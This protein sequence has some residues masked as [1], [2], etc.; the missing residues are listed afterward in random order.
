MTGL[1]RLLYYILN[2]DTENCIN[3]VKLSNQSLEYL[4][5]KPQIRVEALSVVHFVTDVI[6]IVLD[7]V[8]AMNEKWPI[9]KNKAKVARHK[10]GNHVLLKCEERHQT[11]L[12]PEFKGP[13]VVIELLEGDILKSITN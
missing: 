10:V 4:I 3:A 11:K 12:A 9:N 8:N 7:K 2:L 5:V 6:K 1:Q 13:F